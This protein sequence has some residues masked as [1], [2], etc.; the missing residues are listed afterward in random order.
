MFSALPKAVGDLF[1]PSMLVYVLLSLAINGALIVSL[2]YGVGEAL[3][4]TTFF[5]WSWLEWIAD[6]IALVLAVAV[7]LLL[8]STLATI[9]LG[10]YLEPAAA[11]VEARHYPWLG[12]GRGQPTGEVLAVLLRFTLVTLSLNLL[13][14]PIYVFVPVLGV[15]VFWGLNAYLFGREYFELVVGRHAPARDMRKLRRA[16]R[17]R[18]FAGGLAITLAMAIPVANFVAPLWAAA[19]MVHIAAPGLRARAG[20]ARAH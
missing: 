6:A 9:V 15:F 3:A 18:V 19:L 20:L 17:G 1:T 11:R 7:T 4:Q 10:F 5:A 13:A 14:L 12:A 2:W 8:F 16:M